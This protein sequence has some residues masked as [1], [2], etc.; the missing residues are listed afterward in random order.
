MVVLA[1]AHQL[2]IP[3]IPEPAPALPARP[4]RRELV[5]RRAWLNELEDETKKFRELMATRHGLR[6]QLALQAGE[7]RVRLTKLEAGGEG[8][9]AAPVSLFEEVITNPF[10]RMVVDALRRQ[11][12]EHLCTRVADPR[13]QELATLLGQPERNADGDLTAGHRPLPY[14]RLDEPRHPRGSPTGFHWH[15]VREKGQRERFS[16]VRRCGSDRMRHWCGTCQR[17]GPDVALVCDQHR[18]CLECRRRRAHRFQRQM[19]AGMELVQAD[20]E[21][22]Q[23]NRPTKIRADGSLI[24]GGEWTEKFLTLTLPHS[25]DVAADVRE[26]PKAWRRFWRS[27]QD[28]IAHDVLEGDKRP[29]REPTPRDKKRSRKGLPPIDEFVIKMVA[30]AEHRELMRMNRFVRVIEVTEGVDAKGH[31]H[32]HV[33]LV[34]PYVDKYRLAHLWGSALSKPYQDLLVQAGAVAPLESSLGWVD[35]EGT[36]QP[37]TIGVIARLRENLV[38]RKLHRMAIDSI[39]DRERSWYVTRRGPN[40]RPLSIL[41]APVIDVRQVVKADAK[42]GQIARGGVATE[43]C[44]Y[45]IKDCLYEDGKLELLEPSVYARIYAALE[46]RRAIAASR[47]LLT[48]LKKPGCFCVECGGTWKKWID[49]ASIAEPRGPPSQMLLPGV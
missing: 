43:L 32:L 26:L 48:L 18:L 8:N 31:A 41:W 28:H 33:Y 9:T 24:R 22:H 47:H 35:A 30:G 46:G 45:L 17:P 1:L 5:D 39:T 38:R 2:P 21:R 42:E 3:E 20:L 10:P 13:A 19:I 36:H 7:D 4:Y 23:L 34:G 15:K 29:K 44:K 49:G 12:I 11:E 40:G 27:L 6:A 16:R 25:G 14:P 37:G